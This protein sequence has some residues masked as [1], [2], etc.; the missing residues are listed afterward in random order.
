[1]IGETDDPDV[2]SCLASMNGVTENAGPGKC[3]GSKMTDF[4]NR[5]N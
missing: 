1:L 4:E 5:E 3:L 2:E